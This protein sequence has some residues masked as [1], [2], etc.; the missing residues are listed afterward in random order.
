MCRLCKGGLDLHQQSLENLHHEVDNCSKVRWHAVGLHSY[1]YSLQMFWVCGAC[2]LLLPLP[3]PVPVLLQSFYSF[4]SKANELEKQS[5]LLEL[6]EGS[7][8]LPVAHRASC[9]GIVYVWV[10][11]THILWTN[12]AMPT[13]TITTASKPAIIY[14]Y[15][16]IC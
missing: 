5:S 11:V 7:M 2:S 15:Y 4:L 10:V 1:L 13:G 16:T 6:L 12:T 9:N 8:Y 3:I 14:L